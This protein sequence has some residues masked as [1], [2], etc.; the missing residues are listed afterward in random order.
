MAKRSLGELNDDQRRVLIVWAE[1]MGVGERQM[2]N[3]L[4]SVDNVKP[5][6]P[7]TNL[8]S[9]ARVVHDCPDC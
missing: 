3:M 1:H 8:D 2:V 5:V 9:M 6:S 7:W 4:N